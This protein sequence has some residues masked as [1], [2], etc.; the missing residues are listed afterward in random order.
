MPRLAS[1]CAAL[2]QET[3]VS[4][5]PPEAALMIG[6]RVD[7]MR[8]NPRPTPFVLDRMPRPM[9]SRVAVT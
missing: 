7:A 2:E 9:R 5:S 3:D 6:A 8:Q 1:F 4:L